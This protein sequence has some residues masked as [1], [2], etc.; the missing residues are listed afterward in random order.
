MLTDLRTPGVYYQAA[1]AGGPEVTPLRTDI[2]AFVG[3]AERGP[4]DLPVPV[5]SWRQFASW[6][7]DVVPT[8]YL[9]HAVRAFFENGGVRCW[10][11]RVVSCSAVVV[12]AG[13]VPESLSDPVEAWMTIRTAAA[14]RASARGAR[15]RAALRRRRLAIAIHPRKGESEL[16]P[17]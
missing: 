6:F 11:V 5:Q 12:W 2:A 3:I 13:S 1:D 8:G 9:G 14:A 17:L 15:R 10:V 16:R 7:G 4:I